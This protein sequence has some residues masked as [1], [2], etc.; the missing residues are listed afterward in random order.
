M[1]DG[2]D[3]L[4]ATGLGASVVECARC[5]LWFQSPRLPR[6]RHG[7][8]YPPEY[9]PHGQ[10]AI[11]AAPP[12]AMRGYLARRRGYGHLAADAIRRPALDPYLRWR[13]GTQL[14]PAYA[15][16]GRVLDIGSGSGGMLR[17]L[18]ALGWTGLHGIEPDPAAATIARTTGADVRQGAVEDILPGYPDGYFD[19]IV[20]SMVIEHV[21]DPY[22]VMREIAR[23]L[24]P[25]GE[26]LLSTVT[27]D[28]FDAALFGEYWAGFDFPR[29]MTYFRNEDI[30]ALFAERFE[31]VERFPQLGPIDWVRSASWRGRP[32]DRVITRLG[33]RG[34]LMPAAVAALLGR[35]TRV[36]FRARRA[37]T[38]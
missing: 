25:G 1:L 13:A 31:R 20:A 26:L 9:A 21:I 10:P 2:R 4:H 6:A 22:A 28:S 29:H 18:R 16:A 32:V 3:H 5:G 19:A 37:S 33:R 27:R 17:L 7:E 12:A 11:N 24:R 34:M 14:I 38:P 8:L 36:S 15:A 35:S 23:A 30:A